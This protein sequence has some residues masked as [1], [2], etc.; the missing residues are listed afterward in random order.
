[1]GAA[2]RNAGSPDVIELTVPSD[3]RFL[4]LVHSCTE[5]ICRQAQHFSPDEVYKIAW[6]VHEACVNV[7]EHAHRFEASKP[8]R[9]QALLYPDHLEFR[10]YDVGPGFDMEDVPEPDPEQIF[11]RGR[12]LFGMRQCMDVVEYRRATASNCLRLVRRIECIESGVL[13]PP[14][15]A[16]GRD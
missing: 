8:L 16:A 14:S 4:E 15:A 9:I 2:R 7:I 10:V 11:E 6:G 1:M 12:G 13:N 3:A 5:Q